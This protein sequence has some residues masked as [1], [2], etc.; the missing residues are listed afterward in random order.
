MRGEIRRFAASYRFSDPLNFGGAQDVCE[1]L[2]P[3]LPISI[4]G[5]G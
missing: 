3:A 1:Y 5:Y 4:F 2:V